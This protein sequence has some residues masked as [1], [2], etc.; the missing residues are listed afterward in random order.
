MKFTD[1]AQ[2][3]ID[4]KNGCISNGE[5]L[6]KLETLEAE[7]RFCESPPLSFCQENTVRNWFADIGKAAIEASQGRIMPDLDALPI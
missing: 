2:A 7:I 1:A 5:F 3:W 4:W 6:V